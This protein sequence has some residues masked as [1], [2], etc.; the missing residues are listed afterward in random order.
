VDVSETIKDRE[1][2]AH[3]LQKIVNMNPQTSKNR[4][5]ER[6]TQTSKNRK[7]ERGLKKS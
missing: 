6:G 3:K 2:I 4:K 7:Y 5:Y 1:L